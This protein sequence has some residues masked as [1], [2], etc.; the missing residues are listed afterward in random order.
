MTGTPWSR[1]ILI[2]SAV[3]VTALVVVVIGFGW[4]IPGAADRTGLAAILLV[5]ALLNSVFIHRL[6]RKR[7]V[8]AEPELRMTRD[9]R[10]NTEF[11]HE[12]ERFLAEMARGTRRDFDPKKKRSE[13]KKPPP[14]PSRDED[15]PPAPPEDLIARV[16]ENLEILGGYREDLSALLRLYRLLDDPTLT[17]EEKEKTKKEIRRF[18]KVIAL[19]FLLEDSSSVQDETRRLLEGLRRT[20]SGEETVSVPREEWTPVDVKDQ[21]EQVVRS[22]PED[23]TRSAWIDRHGGDV[24]LVLTRPNTL[25]EAFY[26]VLEYFLDLAGGKTIH[27]RTAQRGEDV[28]IG[29]GVGPTPGAS[30]P[31]METDSRVAAA[32][33]LWR[34]LGGNQTLGEGEIQILLPM[35]G[36]ASLFSEKGVRRGAGEKTS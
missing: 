28:W 30:V 34:E 20:L 5:G 4:G 36:P 19:S 29:V 6:L 11:R 17:V 16:A 9:Q 23:R 27:V 25:F 35:H 18:E 15:R 7:G 12:V 24:P 33:G 32:G 10:V 22:L 3:L 13:A 31:E 21:I 2:A 26:Y 1:V 8:P 14:I